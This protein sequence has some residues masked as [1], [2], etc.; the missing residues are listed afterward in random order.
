MKVAVGSDHAGFP[1]KPAV[2]GALDELGAEHV[3]FGCFS[4]ESVDYPDIGSSVARAVAAGEY[5]RGILV[6]GSGIGMSMVANKVHGIRAANCAD[7]KSAALSRAHNDANV[8]ALGARTVAP[9]L[10]VA[11]VKEWFETGFDEGRHSGRLNK[12]TEIEKE[13]SC[14]GG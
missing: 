8:L 2:L 6:C 3:D 5:D 12:M 1:L 9:E 11:I 4:E 14:E 7:V 13:E 10:A